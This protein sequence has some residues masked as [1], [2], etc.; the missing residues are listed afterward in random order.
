ME[1]DTP[2]RK[3]RR[4]AVQRGIANISHEDRHAL[5]TIDLEVLGERIRRA[6]LE[7][8]ISQRDLSNDLFTSAYLSSLEL[9]KTR[10]TP[11]TLT[12]L[13]ERLDKSLDYFL[14]QTNG[15]VSELDE[16]Q[17]RILEVRLSLLNAQTS[18]QRAADD[19]AERALQQV[20]LHQSRLGNSDRARYH[21]LWAV[22]HNAHKEPSKALE[23]LEEARRYLQDQSDPEMEVLVEGEIGAAHFEQRR[24]MPALTHFI[25]ALDIATN[26]PKEVL[27]NHLLWKI[28]MQVANCYLLL[29]DWEQSLKS[30]EEALSKAGDTLDLRAQAEGYFNIA[31]TYS[32]QG[33]FQRACMNLGRSLQ[34]Y[35]QVEDQ[36][37]LLRTRNALAQMQAQNGQYDAAERQAH[38]AL[39]LSQLAAQ[40]DRCQEMSAL[41]T[42]AGIRQKQSRL[43]DAS[44]FVERALQMKDCDNLAYQGRMYQTAAEIAA[45]QGNRNQAEDYYRQALTIL[46]PAS[47]P[48]TLADI[49]HSYGQRLRTW[50]D[51]DKAFEFM[52]K[53]YRQRERGRSDTE[54]K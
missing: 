40:P 45:E 21:Y 6:R 1:E 41:V 43:D 23:E 48:A 29:N 33:D 2:K 16:E 53:A 37:K 28:H 54:S 10:P 49:Y 14:R 19:R 35:E 3:R 50:G 22:F 5:Y 42:L 30:F 18:L 51:V 13:A 36:A 25:N 26:T 7:K 31:N 32:E 15:L 39:K 9:G 12:R 46:E 17:A 11:D 4:M 52:E 47:I 24:I 44:V 38:E 34:I 20:S 8:K 27:T